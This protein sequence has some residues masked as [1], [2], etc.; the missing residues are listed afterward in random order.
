MTCRLHVTDCS[1]TLNDFCSNVEQ[2]WNS[3]KW[4]IYVPYLQVTVT[5]LVPGRSR[6]FFCPPN[7]S[8]GSDARPPSLLDRETDRSVP[9]SSEVKNGWSHASAFLIYLLAVHRG[10]FVYFTCENVFFF[11]L[12]VENFQ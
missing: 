7:I 4:N 3:G 12:E 9:S 5:G 8:T 1:V 11:L 6:R 2:S 10:N